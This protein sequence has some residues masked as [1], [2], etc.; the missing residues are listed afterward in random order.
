[1]DNC[2]LGQL[3]WIDWLGL[4]LLPLSYFSDGGD[5]HPAPGIPYL[6]F[7]QALLAGALTPRLFFILTPGA[8]PSDATMPPAVPAFFVSLAGSSSLQ[9]YGVC[10]GLVV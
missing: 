2:R 7:H 10:R 1:V 9:L 4:P 3:T 6:I 8:D 5:R